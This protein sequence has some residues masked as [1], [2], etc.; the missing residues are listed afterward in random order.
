DGTL[1]NVTWALAD[2][3]YGKNSQTLATHG[4]TNSWAGLVGFNDNH[5]SFFS[6]AQP[7][8]LVFT[9]TAGANQHTVR[10][11]I[12]V[13][14]GPDGRETADLANGPTSAGIPYNTQNTNAYQQTNVFLRPIFDVS[15]TGNNPGNIG[16]FVD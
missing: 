13:S 3:E 10:D 15:G 12:F 4:S 8:N 11:N 9:V 14:E 6:D 5:V 7:D 2:T 1:P 16:L